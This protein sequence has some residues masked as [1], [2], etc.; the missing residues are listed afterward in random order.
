MLSGEETLV[1][2]HPAQVLGLGHKKGLLEAG[3]DADFVVLNNDLDV[4]QT[5]VNG[6][7]F[8]ERK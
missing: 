2:L 8:F 5:W 4:L 1:S 6:T 3:Y 7:C